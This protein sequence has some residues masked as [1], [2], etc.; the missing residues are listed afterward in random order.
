MLRL[1]SICWLKPTTG[2][3]WLYKRSFVYIVQK[4]CN[5][6]YIVDWV[7][8]PC[9][10]IKI[11]LSVDFGG[12]FRG[13]SPINVSCGAHRHRTCGFTFYWRNFNFYSKMLCILWQSVNIWALCG[14]LNRSSALLF[15][16]FFISRSCCQV[17]MKSNRCV[18]EAYNSQWVPRF[19]QVLHL[20]HH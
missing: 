16:Y 12:R 7:T 1:L 17:I 13:R 3:L 15:C 4:C 9:F 18:F 10:T 2:F 19:S 14:L 8:S 11:P 5:T 6:V 20:C